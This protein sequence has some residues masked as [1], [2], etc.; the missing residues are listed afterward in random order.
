[1][2]EILNVQGQKTKDG[3][4]DEEQITLALEFISFQAALTENVNL[5]RADIVRKLLSSL[6]HIPGVFKLAK[7][8][9]LQI[10]DAM[11]VNETKEESSV[12]VHGL[13]NPN[14]NVRNVLLQALESFDLDETETPE[15]LFLALHDSDERNTEIAK[16]IY[17]TNGIQLD[18]YG[19]S[20]LVLSLGKSLL[21][22]C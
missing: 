15:I 2:L 6:S 18:G 22:L 12:L 1:V 16:A 8:A 11:S 10:T 21:Q 14:A 3:S 20:R 13:L 4:G 9:L 19:L 5:P 17:E 7:D